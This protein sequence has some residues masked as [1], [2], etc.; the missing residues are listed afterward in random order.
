[1]GRAVRSVVCAAI[2]ALAINA[3]P[4]YADSVFVN[5]LLQVTG[6]TGTLGGGPF[7][8][9]L[10]ANGS[11][12]LLSFCLQLTQTISYTDTFRI[13]AISNATDDASGPDPISEQTAW[14]YTQFR[15]NA[16]FASLYSGNAFQAAIWSLEEAYDASGVGGALAILQAANAAV[17]NG[18]TSGG[19]VKVLNMFWADGTPAQDL[20]VLVP[21]PEPATMLLLGTG[22]AGLAARRRKQQRQVA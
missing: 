4:A 6:S 10:D 21:V 5:Q 9:D 15:T 14:I 3:K 2:V 1:M 11:Q 13:G 22:L 16:A 17:A 20:L 7:Q 8:V 18:W 19:T 12:D